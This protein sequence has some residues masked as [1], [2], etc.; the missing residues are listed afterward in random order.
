MR[1]YCRN[2]FSGS[3]WSSNNLYF[4]KCSTSD[5]NACIVLV[6]WQYNFG[7]YER[8]K[9]IDAKEFKVQSLGPVDIRYEEVG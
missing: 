6:H 1:Y 8:D 5:S 9:E 4:K 7:S 2:L 3:I